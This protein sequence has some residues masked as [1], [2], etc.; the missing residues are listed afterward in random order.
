M[1]KIRLTIPEQSFILEGKNAQAARDSFSPADI[2]FYDEVL[3]DICEQLED[4][5]GRCGCTNKDSK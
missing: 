1:T 4:A 2:N 3:C 5:D